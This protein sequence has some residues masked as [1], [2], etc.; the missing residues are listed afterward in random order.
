M[1]EKIR[2]KIYEGIRKIIDDDSVEIRDDSE[3]VRDLEL[4]SLE[5]SR[6]LLMIETE[7][8][9]QISDALLRRMNTVEDIINI[10]D[11]YIQEKA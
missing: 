7:F 6:L 3:I 4:S 10:A 1:R 8:G 5:I 2:E 9:I 11:R